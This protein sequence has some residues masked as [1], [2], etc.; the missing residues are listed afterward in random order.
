[1]TTAAD[2]GDVRRGNDYNNNRKVSNE[3]RGR[4]R[5]TVV[6]MVTVTVAKHT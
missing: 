2:R 1:M 4:R 3:G 5:D 6:E